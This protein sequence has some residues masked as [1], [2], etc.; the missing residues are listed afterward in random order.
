MGR[1]A[2]G[3]RGVNLRDEDCLVG[4]TVISDDQEVLVLTEKRFWY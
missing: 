2:T 1:T 4:A 3:V